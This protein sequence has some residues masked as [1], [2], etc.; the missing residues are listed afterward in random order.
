MCA[1][2]SPVVEYLEKFWAETSSPGYLLVD[3]QGRLQEWGG[4]L[5]VYGLKELRAGAPIQ[6][7][8]DFLVGLLPNIDMPLYCPCVEMASGLFT[9]IHVFPAE[10]GDWV[11]LI[12]VSSAARERRQLHQRIHD[13]TLLQ[14]QRAKSLWREV[15]AD[16]FLNLDQ[17]L[18]DIL[19]DASL[20]ADVCAALQILVL[21]RLQPGSFRVIGS[22]PEWFTRVHPEVSSTE[23]DW[24]PGRMFAFLE[25]FLH[26]A[27]MFWSDDTVGMLKSGLWRELDH[28]AN[29]LYLEASAVR[30]GPKKFLLIA[31]SEAAYEERRSIIQRARENS[32]QQHRFDQE[33]QT[34]QTL[35]QAIVHDV[36]GMLTPIKACFALLS[37]EH[38][39]PKGRRCVEL[40]LQQTIR[41]QMLTQTILDVFSAEMGALDPFTRDPT[42]AP[43]VVL[44]TKAVLEALAPAAATKQMTLHL[45]PS[46]A[47]QRDRKVVGERLRLERVIF[48]LVENAIRHNP[49]GT[50]VTVGMKSEAQSILITVDDEGSLVP[51]DMVGALFE[52]LIRRGERS[53]RAGLG[54]YFCRLMVERWGGTIGYSPRPRGGN[55]FWLRL[56]RANAHR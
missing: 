9:D 54:L 47:P 27:E 31:N 51:Q 35:V 21:E 8:V 38:L 50:V 26:D 49:E 6:E 5:S 34:K 11:L 24:R 36:I 37:S 33:M 44:C 39:S 20:L 29:E 17:F 45:H 56:P 7:Q 48:N 18:Q 30:W 43:D 14:E 16:V 12:D 41:Q 42:E 52:K 1:F 46:I 19:V 10:G 2:P 23:P 15:V 13:L 3:K 22:V 53:G 40:G 32:L 25:N 28:S 55:R 4:S